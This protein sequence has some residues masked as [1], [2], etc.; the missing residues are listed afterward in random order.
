M[1][2]DVAFGDLDLMRGREWRR[3]RGRCGKHGEEHENWLEAH[4]IRPA[5][6]GVANTADHGRKATMRLRRQIITSRWFNGRT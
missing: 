6:Y 4:P 1:Q 2:R 3:G 5:R